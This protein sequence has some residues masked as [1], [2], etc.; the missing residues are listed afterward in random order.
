M[1]KHLLLLDGLLGL[2]SSESV[3]PREGLLG[4]FASG[5]VQA[6]RVAPM[7]EARELEAF[8]F[9]PSGPP[10]PEGPLVARALGAMPP[11]DAASLA[12]TVCSLG[13]DGV[14]A[15]PDAISPSESLELRRAVEAISSRTLR[16]VAGDGAEHAMIWIKPAMDTVLQSLP[17][18]LGHPLNAMLPVGEGEVV[19]RRWIDD[20]VNWLLEQEFNERRRDEGRPTLDVLWPWGAGFE[21]ALPHVGLSYGAPVE[22]HAQGLRARGLAALVGAQFHEWNPWRKDWDFGT[23]PI[24]IWRTRGP[25]DAR[26]AGQFERLERWSQEVLVPQLQSWIAMLN[27]EQ[28]VLGIAAWNTQHRGLFFQTQP[29]SKSGDGVPFH[30][31]VLESIEDPQVR[32]WEAVSA[33][34]QPSS[35]PS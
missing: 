12:V 28:D 13:D 27:L 17:A 22:L 10:I 4:N 30:E 26:D 5:R 1:K 32:L 15:R 25:Q 33:F 2:G 6:I 16:G 29:S 21:P 35:S 7:M 18:A 20:S 9:R 23:L 34:F 8:G 14:L 3:L 31:K 11:R 24:T 19:F